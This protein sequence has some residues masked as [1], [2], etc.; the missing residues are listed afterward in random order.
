MLNWYLIA[1]GNTIHLCR[2]ERKN[3][4]KVVSRTRQTIWLSLTSLLTKNSSRK[5]LHTSWSHRLFWS[6]VFVS[7]APLLVLP[8]SKWKSKVWS[9]LSLFMVLSASTPVPPRYFLNVI[10]ASCSI[11]TMVFYSRSRTRLQSKSILITINSYQ[12]LSSFFHLDCF[13]LVVQRM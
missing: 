11:L 7:L 13:S 5:F 2:Q 8:S 6:I 3:G 1:S 12:R 9:R 10:L 4:L